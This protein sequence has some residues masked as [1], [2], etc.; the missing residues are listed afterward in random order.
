V[1]RTPLSARGQR[2]R[3][4]AAIP[5]LVTIFFLGQ[6]VLDRLAW[7]LDLTP[8]RTYTLSEH[9]AGVL[10][11]LTAD[12]RILAFLRSQDPRNMIIRD[13]LRQFELRSSRVRVDTVDV[14]QVRR[15]PA[16]YDVASYGA[17]VVESGDGAGWC[18]PAR[19]GADRRHPAGDAPERRTVGCGRDMARA[20]SP[21]STVIAGLQYRARVLEDEYYDVIQS[22]PRPRRAGWHVGARRSPDRERLPARR[23]GGA[24]SLQRPGQV[25]VMLDPIRPLGLAA[26]L[27][28]CS[29]AAGARASST[30]TRRPRLGGEFLTMEL[31]GTTA[32]R[33]P[34]WRRSRRRRSSP[35]PARSRC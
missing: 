23:A 26:F 13:L 30:R 3:V 32:V 33:T 25:L 20:I 21:A 4:V 29:P 9:A 6:G 14:N 11:D 28:R 1:A 19:R 12:V 18:E 34:C 7:R 16:K 24:R 27:E 8:E 5:A 10:G 15:S 35:A 2:L 17:L 31:E 22:A